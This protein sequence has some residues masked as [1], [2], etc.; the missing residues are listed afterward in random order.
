MAQVG[1]LGVIPFVV[2][3]DM[4][5]TI[6]NVAWSGS[7]RY[8]EHQRHLSSTLTEFT[9]VNPDTFSF[10]MILSAYLGV[11]PMT[12]IVQLCQYENNGI[13]VPVVIGTRSYGKY[14][15]T[16]QKHQIKMTDYD[17]SGNLAIAAVSVELL[18]YLK[19]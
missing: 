15:W 14:R 3:A 18:E 13:A 7:V 4:I 17:K 9:G 11:D 19:E 10:E 6:N 16:V 5:Q 1:C 2:S 12:A 8:G